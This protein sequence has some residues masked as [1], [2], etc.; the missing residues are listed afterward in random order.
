MLTFDQIKENRKQ[1][2][3]KKDAEQEA[4]KN[5]SDTQPV[6][7]VTVN[8]VSTSTNTASENQSWGGS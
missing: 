7:T 5:N 1:F 3:L 8:A 4:L 6:A 2:K